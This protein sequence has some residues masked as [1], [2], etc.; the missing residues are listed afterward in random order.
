M[1]KDYLEESNS[2]AEKLCIGVIN[3]IREKGNEED[4]I[5]TLHISK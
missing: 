3:R 4:W 1:K 2:E 5:E